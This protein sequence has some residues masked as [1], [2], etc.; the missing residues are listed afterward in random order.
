MGNK[1]QALLE[2]KEKI[3]FL[4]KQIEELKKNKE[5]Y[6]I[7][8]KYLTNLVHIKSPNT[9]IIKSVAEY[10]WFDNDLSR[11]TK[12]QEYWRARFIIYYIFRNILGYTY[13]HIAKSTSINSHA[14][15]IA[16]LK[17]N[18][19]NE[20]DK[21]FLNSLIVKLWDYQKTNIEI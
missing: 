18:K 6:Q 7:Q 11:W 19:L 1:W 15:V 5:E 21:E 13:Q 2:L 4:N 12:T 16:S 8:V 17:N 9:F 14:T 20:K 10:F 3:S